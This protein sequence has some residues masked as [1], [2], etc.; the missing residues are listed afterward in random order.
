MV[1]SLGKHCNSKLH[2][3]GHVQGHLVRNKQGH[4]KGHIQTHT[5]ACTRVHTRGINAKWS[6]EHGLHWGKAPYRG[7]SEQWSQEV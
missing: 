2:C 1:G 4:I 5:G 3:M 6:W 7:I